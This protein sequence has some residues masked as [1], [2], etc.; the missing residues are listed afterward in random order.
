MSADLAAAIDRL[1]RAGVARRRN[2]Q[3]WLA[4]M[5]RCRTCYEHQPQAPFC[6]DGK[7]IFGAFRLLNSEL[8][9]A[10]DLVL[11]V[12]PAFGGG[13]LESRAAREVSAERKPLDDRHPIHREFVAHCTDVLRAAADGRINSYEEILGL[14]GVTDASKIEALF[15]VV[16]HGVETTLERAD[17]SGQAAQAIGDA[18]FSAIRFGVRLARKGLLE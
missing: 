15:I 1:A 10:S 7:T 14:D 3:R 6:P 17:A 12:D 11:M 9:A 4:H 13:E 8:D 16:Q 2:H 18:I 5:G